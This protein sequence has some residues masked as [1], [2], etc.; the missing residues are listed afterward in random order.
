MSFDIGFW[1]R[2]FWAKD[3]C[4]GA[5]SQGTAHAQTR[6]GGRGFCRIARSAAGR[7]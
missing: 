6:G 2:L 4:G 5:G 7:G 3:G 1:D